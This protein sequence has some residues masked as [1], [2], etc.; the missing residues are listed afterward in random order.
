[1]FCSLHRNEGAPPPKKKKKTTTTTYHLVH[2][3]H[4]LNMQELDHKVRKQHINGLNLTLT[5][6]IETL[7]TKT[8]SSA[9]F[10]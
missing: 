1:M 9:S 8:G 3:L 5:D 6:S 4:E 7:F 10:I 2:P